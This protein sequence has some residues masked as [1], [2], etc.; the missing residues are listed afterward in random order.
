[1]GYP[2]CLSLISVVGKFRSDKCIK[3]DPSISRHICRV[4]LQLQFSGTDKYGGDPTPLGYEY[5]GNKYFQK[6]S[7]PIK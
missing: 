7:N 3:P 4:S 5:V 6:T 2:A 1:M